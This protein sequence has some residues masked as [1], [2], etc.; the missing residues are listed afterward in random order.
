IVFKYMRSVPATFNNPDKTKVAV[1]AARNLVGTSSVNDA[2]R[3][4]M[5]AE[6]F[7]Y[8]LQE[9]P[10]AYIFVGNGPTAACHHPAFDFDDEALPYGIGWWV[11]LVETILAP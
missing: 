5:G 4:F 2:V 10:G 6:D 11:K 8:M 7:A 9:R 1:T 3:V